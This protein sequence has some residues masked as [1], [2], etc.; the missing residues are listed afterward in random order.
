MKEQNITIIRIRPREEA[1]TITIPNTLEAL[2]KEVD[3]Y[4][5]MVCPYS[6]YDLALVVNEEGKLL[7]L[8]RNFPL[9]DKETNTAVDIVCGTALIVG[10]DEEG[11][12]RSLTAEEIDWYKDFYMVIGG[13]DDE[14]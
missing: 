2:Q 5:E 14:E 4:I 6:N 13:Q 12:C 9:I 11:E 3:G 10:I 7:N 8:D 1:E